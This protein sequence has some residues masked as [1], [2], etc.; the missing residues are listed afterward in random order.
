MLVDMS[1]RVVPVYGPQIRSSPDRIAVSTT[2]VCQTVSSANARSSCVN[3]SRPNNAAPA[4]GT[5][6]RQ[7]YNHSQ[8]M[9]IL[10][11]TCTAGMCTKQPWGYLLLT[12]GQH[13]SSQ[14]QM[15]A[16]GI[17]QYPWIVRDG[18][19]VRICRIWSRKQC[20]PEFFFVARLSI[21]YGGG[22]STHR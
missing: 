15:V 16:F 1:I 19:E 3:N 8:S 21:D 4:A 20:L 11:R 6:P 22:E 14:L 9:D 12:E 17:Y 13:R 7:Q 2:L 10:Y 5:R 18:D